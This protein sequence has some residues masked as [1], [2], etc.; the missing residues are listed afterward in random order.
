MIQKTSFLGPISPSAT[1]TA[2]LQR[3]L[4][5]MGPIRQKGHSPRPN[6]RRILQTE[7]LWVTGALLKDFFFKESWAALSKQELTDKACRKRPKCG[8]NG[9]AHSLGARP[10]W[11]TFS[12]VQYIFIFTVMTSMINYMSWSKNPYMDLNLGSFPKKYIITSHF[13]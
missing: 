5:L 2:T 13:H 1:F 12:S 8:R 7:M 9:C 3:S 10:R 11:S 6:M 4:R